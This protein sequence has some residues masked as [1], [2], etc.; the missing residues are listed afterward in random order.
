MTMSPPFSTNTLADDAQA[1]ALEAGMRAARAFAEAR[2]WRR[3]LAALEQVLSSNP[4][5]APAHYLIGAYRDCLGEHEQAVEACREAVRL[6][7][8]DNV[9]HRMLGLVLSG[10]RRSHRAALKHIEEAIRL[11]PE[12]AWN[13]YTMG[14]LRAAMS[15]PRKALA[16]FEKA[17]SLAPNDPPLLALAAEHCFGLGRIETANAYAGRAYLAD[18]GHLRAIT[19]EARAR[20]TQ[21]RTAEALDL[22]RAAAALDASDPKALLV[23]FEIEARRSPLCAAWTRL[24]EWAGQ[25]RL[26]VALL[27]IVTLYALSALITL[28]FA[29]GRFGPLVVAGGSLGLVALVLD[30]QK[31][32]RW[33]AAA[34][35]K[36]V[37]LK[38]SF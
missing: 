2:N 21:G 10:R 19:A 38:S 28:S 27:G 1:G 26:R 15:Q 23:L 30:P 37:R 13:H 9:A 3:A 25:S 16:S 29:A 24:R 35:R 11:A 8:A 20:L 18:P 34:A 33:R 6:A 31:R 36:R 32:A 17:I 4:D 14:G 5:H 22:A 12:D 7:P